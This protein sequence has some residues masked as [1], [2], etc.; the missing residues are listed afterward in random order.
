LKS[1]FVGVEA[2]II[3]GK[4]AGIT[5]MVVG[6]DSQNAEI[7]VEPGT[8]IVIDYSNINQKIDMIKEGICPHCIKPMKSENGENISETEYWWE[9]ECGRSYD[10][11]TGKDI[12]NYDC[13]D[14][15]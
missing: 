12:T 11:E 4:C 9:C 7:K 3:K 10:T 2:T 8:R 14:I 6:A 15:Y 1:V 5:G 13:T